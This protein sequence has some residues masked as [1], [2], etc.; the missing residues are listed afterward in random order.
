MTILAFILWFVTALFALGVVTHFKGK[1]SKNN[2]HFY[3]ARDSDDA[4]Y[5]YLGK[6]VRRNGF[7]GTSDKSVV[8]G[9]DA[10]FFLEK[11]GL[12]WENFKGLK[13]EDEPVE[14]FLNLED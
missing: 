14:V 7:W 4:L 8:I 10:N 1:Q 3:V 9:G 12:K 6:P 2:V 13:W 11:C 5:F